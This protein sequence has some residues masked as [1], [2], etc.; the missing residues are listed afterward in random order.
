MVKKQYFSIGRSSIWMAVLSIVMA[1]VAGYS[2]HLSAETAA[3]DEKILVVGASGRTG[4]Y[5]IATLDAQ[6]R[7]YSP[8][9]T[10]IERAKAKVPGDHDWVQ[11]DVRDT[12]SLE[13][14]MEGV[15][16]ILSALGA[17]Q[18]SGPNSPEFI[19]WEGN[20]NLIDVAKAAGVKHF[21]MLSAAGVTQENHSMNRLGD[22]M[23]YKLKAENYLRDS[24]VPY[25][26]V[27]PGG[28]ESAPSE[29]KGIVMEQGDSM[30]NHGGFSRADLSV[31]L[32]ESVGN[33][34][35][36]SK[37]FEP[38]YSDDA[39]VDAWRS[40]FGELLNDTDQKNSP[41]AAGPLLTSEQER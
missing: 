4:V 1:T 34:N 18:F 16:H 35:A 31:L 7:S 30:P 41:K 25:T 40:Q 8:M 38:I 19:D 14:A 36:Y 20:R 37:S 28:L 2:T 13:T 24:G 33:V 32:V 3:V 9:T 21:V 10:S 5:I 6:G 22:V 29:N 11:A 26:I 27:R 39:A 15:T 23:I 12:A 17:T